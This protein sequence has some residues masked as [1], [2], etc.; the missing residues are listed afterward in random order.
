MNPRT[1]SARRQIY[2]RVVQA[3]AVPV[4]SHI[5]GFWL[6]VRELRIQAEDRAPRGRPGGLNLRR[7]EERSAA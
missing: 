6:L 7:P 5:R 1:R 2:R 3:E 4:Y